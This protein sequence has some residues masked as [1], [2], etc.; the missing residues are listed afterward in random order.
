MKS[1]TI[2]MSLTSDDSL[3][4]TLF[5]EMPM[6]VFVPAWYQDPT[7][8]HIE[9]DVIGTRQT[10]LCAL[11]LEIVSDL[12]FFLILTPSFLL[13]FFS[14]YYLLF[15]F[16]SFLL[17]IFFFPLVFYIFFF[18]PKF[19]I[20]ET[21][22]SSVDY[23]NHFLQEQ[24]LPLL[25]PTTTS[26][27]SSSTTSA[28]TKVS[29]GNMYVDF[30]VQKRF[31]ELKIF[32]KTLKK[33][34]TST[35]SRLMPNLPSSIDV[36]AGAKG[37]LSNVAKTRARAATKIFSSSSST[38]DDDISMTND[39]RYRKSCSRSNF[40]QYCITFVVVDLGRN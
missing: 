39:E 22:L 29:S 1:T 4:S 6:T 31:S 27:T 30:T 7:D 32:E 35:I 33:L 10:S 24:H 17:F 38:N 21:V 11:F 16:S 20:F 2:P 19:V 23:L 12:L 34:T 14:S 15:F 37:L 3:D 36:V 8:G 5:V 25:E 26:T 40:L 28:T 9:Y 18:P 13:F